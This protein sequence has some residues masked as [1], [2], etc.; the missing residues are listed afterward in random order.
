MHLLLKTAQMQQGRR[1][2]KLLIINFAI[3]GE[4]LADRRPVYCVEQTMSSPVFSHD[5]NSSSVNE[6]PVM[7]IVNQ[8][9]IRKNGYTA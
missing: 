2:N 7:I 1:F 6:K 4:V 5:H 9:F 8:Y 3:P